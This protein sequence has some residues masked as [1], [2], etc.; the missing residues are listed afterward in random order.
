MKNLQII[1][2]GS[3]EETFVNDV[4]VK[5]FAQLKIFVSAR[6]IKTGWDRLNNKPAKGGLLKYIKFR[7]DV[8]RWI[9]RGKNLS[10]RQKIIFYLVFATCNFIIYFYESGH[11]T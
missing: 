9:H 11:V 2:E 10:Q 7:N 6:K 8:L 1:V 3:S 5:H 4:M